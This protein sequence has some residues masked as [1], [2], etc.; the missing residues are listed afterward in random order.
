VEPTRS[1][2]RAGSVVISTVFAAVL[3]ASPARAQDRIYFPAV[4]DVR[5]VLVE[6][7]NRE[8]VRIDMGIWYLTER[9]IS[10]ALVDRFRAGITVRLIGDRASI[11]EIDPHTKNEFYWLASQGVPIRLRYHPTS[12][13]EIMHWK[14]TI[15]VGQNL[16][17]FG[18][19]NYTPFELAPVSATNYKDETVLVSGDPDLVNAFKARFDR[20][21]NDTTVE[22]N[23]RFGGPPYLL[24]WDE[25]CAREPACADYRTRYPNATPML[26]NRSRLEPDYSMP[27]DLVWGQ[28]RIFNDRLV[29]EIRRESRAIDLVVY[30]LTVPAVAQA[31]LDQHRAGVPVRLIIE[32]K[33]YGNRTWPEFWLTHAFVDALWAAGVPIKQRAHDGLTHMKMLITSAVATNASSNI[34]PHW[35]RDHNYFVSAARTPAVHDAMR[36]RFRAMWDDAAGFVPFSPGPPDAPALAAPAAGAS[37]VSRT[38]TLVWARA[39]FATSY[40]VYMGTSPARLTHVATVDAALVPEP[41]AT[42][43]W[44]VPI[45]LEAHTSYAWR[46]VSRTFAGLSTA[47][48]VRM[49]TTGATASPSPPPPSPPSPSPPPPSPPPP[50]PSPEPPAPSPAP[51][52][53][54]ASVNGA[55]VVLEWSTPPAGT[56]RS[57]VVVA[58]LAPGRADFTLPTHSAS[59]FAVYDAVPPGVYYVRVHAQYDGRVGPP[60]EELEVAVGVPHPPVNLSADVAGSDVTLRWAPGS[61]GADA[62]ITHYVVEAGYSPGASNAAAGSVGTLT[63]IR[64]TAVPPGTYYVRVRAAHGALVSPPSNE[65]V[66]VVP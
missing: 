25:A 11:F 39:A 64:V 41:P 56:P 2:A 47:S 26:I 29:Q 48:E 38:P 59:P 50:S 28:G 58:G 19:A 5:S 40:D 35:Q 49:F 53:V 61:N 43:S 13:P 42:Y 37:D 62:R 10:Q 55:R 34:A 65:I 60:S 27:S 52:N 21:W 66:V 63:A 7:I 16:V 44:T 57:Y 32:P 30:R 33:E 51:T 18:S 9:R 36:S 14:A 45:T 20:I 1:A 23:S 15:F 24:D 22:P 6:H 17:A 46:V 8:T 54:R 3:T 12:F 4:E 31:L